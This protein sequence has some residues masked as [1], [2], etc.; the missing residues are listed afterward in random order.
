MPSFRTGYRLPQTSFD[1]LITGRGCD[2]TDGAVGTV[3]HA[4]D[5]CC[6]GPFLQGKR[7][8]L[9]NGVT[10]LSAGRHHDEFGDVFFIGDRRNFLPC[11]RFYYAC[12]CATRVTF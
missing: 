4:V 11:G 1:V 6:L 10:C 5:L 9:H 2:Q 3:F 8:L 12:E 7:P